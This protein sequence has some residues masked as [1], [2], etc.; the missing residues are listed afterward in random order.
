MTDT[1]LV[2]VLLPTRG[3]SDQ[4]ERCLAAMYNNMGSEGEDEDIELIMRVNPDKWD[5]DLIKASDWYET[6][7]RIIILIDTLT[8]YRNLHHYF[9][10]MASLST[11]KWIFMMSDDG[12]I[13]TEGWDEVL[14]KLPVDPEREVALLQPECNGEPNCFPIISRAW[15]EQL[16]HISHHVSLDGYL[17]RI[18]EAIGCMYPVDIYVHHEKHELTGCPVDETRR[19]RD[20]FLEE[21]KQ[22]PDENYV[23]A[24]QFKAMI[25]KDVM[26]LMAYRAIV[27][28]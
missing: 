8:G 4:L 20:K 21:F 14:R 25:Y 22:N 1:P 19:E 9:N 24:P 17:Q 12:F 3:R 7:M 11:G 26:S 23:D 16:G 28:A 10:Q 27:G 18:G 15:Y 2:S 5:T 13:Q 6:Q